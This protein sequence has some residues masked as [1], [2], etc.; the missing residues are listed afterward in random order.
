MAK[1]EP[2]D[3]HV[4]REGPYCMVIFSMIGTEV[5]VDEAI[6]PFETKV[7]A[8]DHVFG[9]N[10]VIRSMADNIMVDVNIPLIVGDRVYVI[11]A[12]NAPYTEQVQKLNVPTDR[13]R[14]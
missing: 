7:A 9:E 14:K 5:Q 3:V 2:L 11:S 10:T 4:D 6:G 12:L 8:K 1:P 13:R